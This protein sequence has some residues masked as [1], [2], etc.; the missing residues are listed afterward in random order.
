M[1]CTLRLPRINWITIIFC[2]FFKHLLYIYKSSA[3]SSVIQAGLQQSRP[4]A[5]C[6]YAILLS[7]CSAVNGSLQ[8][9]TGPNS[10]CSHLQNTTVPLEK[11]KQSCSARHPEAVQST[12][13]KHLPNGVRSW[14]SFLIHL[15]QQSTT[16]AAEETRWAVAECPIHRRSCFIIS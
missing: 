11:A 4:K 8:H 3:T 14:S 9:K 5:K 13:S 7:L 1:T 6:S 12:Q 10:L 16:A 2:F 15:R